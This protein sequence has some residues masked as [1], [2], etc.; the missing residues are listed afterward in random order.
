V[1]PWPM[2]YPPMDSGVPGRP[3]T[4]AN[5]VMTAEVAAIAS[6]AAQAISRSSSSRVGPGGRRRIVLAGRRSPGRSEGGGSRATGPGSA[7]P[8]AR[9]LPTEVRLQI[10]PD[11]VQVVLEVAQMVARHPIHLPVVDVRVQ[12][13]EQ[14]AEPSS[15]MMAMQSA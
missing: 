13:H 3:L 2:V 10:P 9:A 8:G 4:G 15:A 11:R 7:W 1:A 6:D 12:V 14:V 5:S